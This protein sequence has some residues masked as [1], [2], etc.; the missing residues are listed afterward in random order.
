MDKKCHNCFRPEHYCSHISI[1]LYSSKMQSTTFKFLLDPQTLCVLHEAWFWT[2]HSH[3]RSVPVKCMER[4][5][6]LEY[7]L[8]LRILFW[9]ESQRRT[10]SSSISCTSFHTSWQISFLQNTA[11]KSTSQIV[12][13]ITL[14]PLD[15][16]RSSSLENLLENSK[17]IL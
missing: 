17:H 16:T 15:M 9:E 4:V 2:T 11:G 6:M 13:N 12:S 14:L 5:Y 10:W 3:S 7:P 8:E 1:Y